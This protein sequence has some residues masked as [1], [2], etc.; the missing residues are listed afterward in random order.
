[1][2]EL[3]KPQWLFTLALLTNLTSLRAETP[4]A[5]AWPQWRGPL[6]TGYSP[7]ANPPLNWS[8]AVNIAWKVPIPG[9][10]T[11]SPVVWNDRIFIATA[12]P[13]S[14]VANPLE[15]IRS[16]LSNPLRV[17]VTQSQAFTLLAIDRADGRTRWSRTTVETTPHQGTHPDGTWASS[18]PVTDGDSVFVFFGSYGVFCYDM[19]GDLRWKVDL[20]NMRIKLGFGE[21]SSP[22]L[23]GDYLV[24]NWD[25][26][27]ESFIVALDKHTG[28]EIWRTERAEATTWAT[29]LVTEYNGRAQ[30]ITGA[31]NRV[32]SYD[33]KTGHLLW[34]SP[35]LTPNAIPTPVA[36]SDMVFVT[37]GFRGN[38]LQAI[39]LDKATG[40]LSN[41]SAIAWTHDR[42]TPYVPS[43]LLHD[44]TLYFTKHNRAI[45]SAFEASTGNEKYSRKRLNGIRAVY[46]S[47]VGA[48]GRI[49]ITGRNGTT[50]VLEH[51]TEFKVLA[52]NMLDDGFDASAALIGN[53]IFL[54]GYEN[55]YC[56]RRQ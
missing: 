55:L 39:R 20:G 18:S 51:G 14:S 27:D 31:T 46:A 4:A 32:R 16:S 48:A 36:S 34:E 2:R 35:G 33:L 30:I 23:H 28:R 53:D 29:P 7:S 15:A 44:D 56:V 10:G 22:A 37:S 19:D 47:P 1:M 17:S 49:Y 40:D 41:T 43:P 5:E 6:A 24:I 8:E 50:L 21:A 26:E 25:H 13:T 11:S 3:M 45:L 42:D 38:A 12:I 54:R 9:R 52:K